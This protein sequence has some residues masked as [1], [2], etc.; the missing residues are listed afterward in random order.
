LSKI[1]I[2][3]KVVIKPYDSRADEIANLYISKIKS[4]HPDMK[5]IHMGASNLGISGQGDI[6]IYVLFG[7]TNFD[8][9]KRGMTDV[10][11]EPTRQNKNDIVW[12]F[13]NNS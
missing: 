5:V 11:G 2:D 4:I 3:K 7:S 8:K 12:E 1:P 10:L 13:D 9:Y 6:D